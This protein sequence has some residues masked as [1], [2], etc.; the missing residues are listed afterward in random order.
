MS[1]LQAM[2]AREDFRA[3]LSS[4]SAAQ[5][6]S[7]LAKFRWRQE[8]CRCYL[9][10]IRKIAMIEGAIS[11]CAPA[12]LDGE[13]HIKASTGLFSVEEL[14]HKKGLPTLRDID[15][16]AESVRSTWDA[17]DIRQRTLRLGAIKNLCGIHYY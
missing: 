14:T 4:H 2:I 13:P 15:S 7:W 6:Q 5:R 11:F 1:H 12:Y 9:H 3:I 16:R 10:E 8:W 17:A